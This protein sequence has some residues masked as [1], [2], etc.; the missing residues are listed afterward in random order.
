M[1]GERGESGARE[2][3]KFSL[4]FFVLSLSF[5]SILPLLDHVILM[6][7]YREEISPIYGR[8]IPRTN[9]CPVLF[10]SPN[11]ILKSLFLSFSRPTK[12]DAKVSS[13]KNKKYKPGASIA[14]ATMCTQ[15]K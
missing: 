11:S 8:C 13:S 3:R 15:K 7:Q 14:Q 10:K 9:S 4:S 12:K 2:L 6:R 1:D 5:Y